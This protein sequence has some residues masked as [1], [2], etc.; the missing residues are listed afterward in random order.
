MEEPRP[1]WS[2]QT[3]LTVSLL[4]LVFGVYLIYLFRAAIGP[5][6]LALVIA[7]VL[8]P[9]ATWFEE[10]L[11]VRRSLAALLAY[12]V[13]GIIL[14]SIPLII[15]PPLTAQSTELNLDFQQ[16]IER[17]EELIARRYEVSGFVIDL[18]RIIGQVSGSIVAVFEPFVGQTL[19][20]A[21]DLITSLVWVV[22][23]FVVSFYLV[24]DG[25]KVIFWLEGLTP[26]EYRADFINL[27]KEINQIWNAFFRGQILLVLVV[28]VIFTI[29]G[30]VIGLPFA[31]AMGVLAGLLELLPSIGHGIWLTIASILSLFLGSTWL[32]IPNWIFAL[33]V[34]GL[35]II[36]Q[37]FDLN[38]L[39][40]RIIGRR[41][42]LHPLVVIVGIVTGA[43]VAGV[44]GIFL[45]API[46]ATA[47]VLGKYIYANLLDLDPFPE[48]TPPE[49]PPPKVRWWKKENVGD[50][51]NGKKSE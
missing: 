37:Q 46:I 15:V 28:A 12:L 3:K 31:L 2:S 25:W 32:P 48:T 17:I 20:Y 41:V 44:L 24:L 34:I 21:I 22:F 27:R 42:Q 8:S 35:H 13:A 43:L 7:Y 30:L 1:Q 16:I 18:E 50:P 45:A 4:L 33:V 47:R 10:R 19:S 39:L 26:V 36:F 23:V 9:L 49:L 51:N 5:F 38:Y 6:I 29:G 40:P 14:A 11:K